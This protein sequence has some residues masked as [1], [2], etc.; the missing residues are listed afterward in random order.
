[1]NGFYS[2]IFPMN[3]MPKYGDPK[4]V[5]GQSGVYIPARFEAIISISASSKITSLNVS[6]DDMKFKIKKNK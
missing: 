1:M 5:K 4:G 3:F 6:H 2:F